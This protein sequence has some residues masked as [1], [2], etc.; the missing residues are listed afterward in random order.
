[1]HAIRADM[2]KKDWKNLPEAKLIPALIRE[3]PACSGKM[4]A[5]SQLSK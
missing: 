5:R 4:I 3:V 1:M 2:S